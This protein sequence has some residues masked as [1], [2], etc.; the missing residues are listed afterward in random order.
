[1]VRP[2]Q[3]KA[4][5]EKGGWELVGKDKEDES[6]EAF[7]DPLV[8]EDPE[9]ESGEWEEEA[10]HQKIRKRRAPH[11]EEGASSKGGRG[12]PFRKKK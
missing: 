1:M 10:K 5:L 3:R 12:R 7:L 9:G 11:R 2:G 8:P 6:F 4:G